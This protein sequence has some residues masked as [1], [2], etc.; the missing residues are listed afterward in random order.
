[1]VN[2]CFC[3]VTTVR[4]RGINGKYNSNLIIWWISS[5]KIFWVN[6]KNWYF[7]FWSNYVTIYVKTEG[8]IRIN[9]LNRLFKKKYSILCK[10]ET[11]KSSK[12]STDNIKIIKTMFEYRRTMNWHLN[13]NA[14][15]G[16]VR[17][18]TIFI[19]NKMI[20]VLMSVWV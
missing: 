1:M 20:S 10:K 14:I 17:K 8:K 4:W 13:A 12:F 19:Y 2:I 5:Y 3:S 11:I 16:N 15:L 6:V 9:Y 7:I 18:N